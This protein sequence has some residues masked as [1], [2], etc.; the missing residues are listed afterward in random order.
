MK[1]QVCQQ[2]PAS[3]RVT[4]LREDPKAPPGPAGTLIEEQELCEAC[5][6]GLDLPYAPVQVA[7]L[8]VWKL[9]QSGVVKADVPTQSCPECGWTLTDFRTKGRLGCPR[10]YEVFREHIDDLLE[11]IHNASEH[12]GRLPGRP[13][14]ARSA[15][16]DVE[17]L[18]EELADAIR[19]EEYERA[20]ELRDRL[21][22]LERD[23]TAGG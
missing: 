3:I 22:A 17:T 6:K 23:P 4:E 2:K 8:D 5:A 12:H 14:A 19:A 21:H 16:A 15:Q 7:L 13:E 20:A 9:L 18:R 11:R 1:C 10:D